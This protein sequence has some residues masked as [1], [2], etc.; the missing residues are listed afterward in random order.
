MAT[1]PVTEEKL[2]LGKGL[3]A[4]FDTSMGEIVAKLEEEKT[5]GT[6][7][8][9]VGLATGEKEY[10]DPRTGKKGDG[11]YY[12]GTIFHRVIKGFMVQTGDPTGTGRGGP[13]YTIKDELVSSLRHSG[14]GIL[15]M[16]KTSAPDSG[17]SQ[18]FITLGPTP[19]LDGVH[20]VFGH[21]VR[22]L[23]NVTAIGSVKTSGS[24]FDRPLQDVVI[25]TLRIV[26]EV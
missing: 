9:F 17:G 7:K 23:E 6:V 21:V 19:H 24:P 1:R 15:S 18:Y 26:R 4:I 11:P 22:G 16:A 14:P 25:K 2:G 12:D 8:N 3:Y 10:V 20:S 5:P 13:G